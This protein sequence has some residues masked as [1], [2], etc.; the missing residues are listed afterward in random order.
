[1]EDV[2]ITGDYISK[3]AGIPTRTSRLRWHANTRSQADDGAGIGPLRNVRLEVHALH[4][5]ID[6]QLSD[7]GSDL[8]KGHEHL[9]T[10]G[11]RPGAPAPSN[12]SH[13]SLW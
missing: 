9:V 4:E 5:W 12:G 11:L 1:M 2:D 10:A 8:Q 3:G 7:R 6:A 13:S